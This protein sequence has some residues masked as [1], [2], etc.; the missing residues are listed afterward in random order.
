MA[1]RVLKTQNKFTLSINFVL[2]NSKI[3]KHVLK[4]TKSQN[5]QNNLKCTINFNI[6]FVVL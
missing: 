3:K 6:F 5:I 4:T 1:N 2:K